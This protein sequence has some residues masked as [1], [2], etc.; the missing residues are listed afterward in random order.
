[1]HILIVDDHVDF[2]AAISLLLKKLGH[3]VRVA[4]NGP[5]AIQAARAFLP[6]VVL[7]DI[8]LPGMNGCEVARELRQLPEVHDVSL[9][10]VTGFGDDQTRSRALESGFD[11]FLVKPCVVDQL[12]QTL[13][14]ILAL[15]LGRANV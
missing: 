1:M 6:D 10:A 13:A 3:E 11:R 8:G 7:L 2:I 14:E 5:A 15:R 4:D 12:Q 9:V